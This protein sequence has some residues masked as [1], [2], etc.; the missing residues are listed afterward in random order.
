MLTYWRAGAG[1]LRGPLVVGLCLLCFVIGSLMAPPT[2]TAPDTHA[3]TTT[4]AQVT[5]EEVA[6]L[7]DALE[8]LSTSTVPPAQQPL[9][10]EAADVLEQLAPTVSTV[11]PAPT[12]TSTATTT[13]TLPATTTTTT[14][15]DTYRWPTTTETTP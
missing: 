6:R 10:D 1:A 8:A 3:V 13:T 11:P 14:A 9:V 15:D 5:P 7:A 2:D 4:V 12:T